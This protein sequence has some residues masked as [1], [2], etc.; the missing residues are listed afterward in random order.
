MINF[1]VHILFRHVSVHQLKWIIF[2]IIHISDIGTYSN[3][4]C[5]S[6]QSSH[7]TLDAC[8]FIYQFFIYLYFLTQ[9]V[10][11]LRGNFIYVIQE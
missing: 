2:R 11:F 6:H 7:C 8:S 1:S 5:I 9:Q 3:K 4:M 10:K